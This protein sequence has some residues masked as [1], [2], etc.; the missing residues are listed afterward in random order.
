MESKCL[1]RKTATLER[2]YNRFKKT[3]EPQDWVKNFKKY[4]SSRRLS[5]EMVDFFIDKIVVFKNNTI[6][7]KFKFSKEQLIKA[8]AE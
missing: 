5:K 6:D 7:I 3:M 4:R 1:K 2:E 8:E